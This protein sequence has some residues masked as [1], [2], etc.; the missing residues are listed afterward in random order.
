MIPKLLA[1]ATG[2]MVLALNEIETLEEG[3]VQ[4]CREG[5]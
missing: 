3:F 5:S 4:E 1:S 2:Y